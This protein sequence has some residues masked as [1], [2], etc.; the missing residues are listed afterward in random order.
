MANKT[1]QNKVIGQH[2]YQ[3]IRGVKGL[4]RLIDF[5]SFEAY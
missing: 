3:Q 5:I 4:R 2:G 1:K